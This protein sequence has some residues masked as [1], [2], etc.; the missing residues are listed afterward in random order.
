MVPRGTEYLKG[1]LY[2]LHISMVILDTPGDSS[3]ISVE[4]GL[5][6]AVWLEGE[7]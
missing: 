7:A 6:G 3:R 5:R 4:E 2:W 1:I